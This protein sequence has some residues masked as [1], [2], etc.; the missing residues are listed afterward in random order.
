MTNEEIE[1]TMQFILQ[2]QAEFTSNFQ[3]IEEARER[4]SARIKQLEESFRLLVQL[5]RNHD[6][7]LVSLAEAQLRT[8]EQLAETDERLN[9]LISV[10]ERYIT[11]KGQNGTS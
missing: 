6:E 5:A 1:K 4:D 9:S 11:S 7:R 10:V 3:K 2:Q 8:S